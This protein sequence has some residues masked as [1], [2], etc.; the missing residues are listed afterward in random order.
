MERRQTLTPR[1]LAYLANLCHDCRECLYSCQYA[2]PHEFGVDVPRLM[3]AA[4]RE[5]YRNYAWPSA[6][7]GLFGRQWVMLALAVVAA[8]AAALA[9]AMIALN[10]TAIQAAHAGAGA[11]YAVI[12]HGW[13]VGLFSV[14]G[15]SSAIAC[16]IGVV[17]FWR[18]IDGARPD[19]GRAGSLGQGLRDAL[20]LRY[21]GG[22]GGGCAYP[23]EAASD[24]RRWF[25]H[26]TFYGFVSCFAATTVAAFYENVLNDAAPYPLFS[27]PVMLGSIG[28]VGLLVGPAGLLWLKRAVPPEGVDARQRPMDVSFLILLWL[29]AATGFVLLA[30]RGSTAMGP[31]LIIHLG[32]VAGLFV[33]LP[34]G[35]FVHGLYRTA[36]LV[37]YARESASSRSK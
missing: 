12:P 31:L 34:Y 2:P 27:L 7:G 9:I 24:I 6:F 33:S 10:R 29:T 37:R 20:T 32:V 21:L 19:E 14:L 8:P 13:M 30:L 28:G 1:D 16:A 35:K 17:R 26:L 11:F 25:H 18:V 3:A 5:S 22:G 23:D 4:R 15:V 36:A